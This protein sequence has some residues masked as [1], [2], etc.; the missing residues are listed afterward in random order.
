MKEIQIVI[1]WNNG[2]PEWISQHKKGS[3]ITIELPMNWYQNNDL[4]GVALCS[5]YVPFHIE[6][7]ED[8]CRLEYELN[9]HGH[10][11]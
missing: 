2:I 7:K 11:L 10:Q 1:P 6:S 4:L 3:H 8:P 9:F 5:V